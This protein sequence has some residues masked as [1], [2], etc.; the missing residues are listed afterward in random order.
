MGVLLLSI[1]KA[2]KSRG[3]SRI[4]RNRKNAELIVGA[5]HESPVIEKLP[6]LFE[7]LFVF[8]F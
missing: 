4:A 6:D 3:D 7:E 8:N 5:I 1:I 2:I